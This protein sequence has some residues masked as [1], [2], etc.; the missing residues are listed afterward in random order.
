MSAESQDK[1]EKAAEVRISLHADSGYTAEITG[2]ISATQWGEICAIVH[3]V[4]DAATKKE[5]GE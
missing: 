4:T 2:R 1:H 5:E 3:G